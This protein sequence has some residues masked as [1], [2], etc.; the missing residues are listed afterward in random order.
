MMA[1]DRNWTDVALR[2]AERAAQPDLGASFEDGDDH[3]VGHPDGADDLMPQHRDLMTQHQDLRVLD[4]WRRCVGQSAA[5]SARMR[6]D[7]FSPVSG[8]TRP[9]RLGVHD[10]VG[11]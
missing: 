2:G 7:G 8:I 4:A 1:S 11:E 6:A 9:R 5:C 10:R 3:D